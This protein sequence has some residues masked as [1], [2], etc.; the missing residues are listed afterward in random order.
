MSKRLVALLVALPLSLAACGSDSSSTSPESS[1]SAAA[2]EAGAAVDGTLEDVNVTGKAGAEPTVEVTETP[3]EAEET[4]AQV[5]EEGSGDVVVE[6]GN[7][8]KAE[9]VVVNGR[10][11]EAIESSWP[12][13]AATAQPIFDVVEG[14]LLPGL[15]KGLLGQ[16]Q[17]SR[18]AIAAPAA[19][20]FA[21]QGMPQAGIEPG[22]TIVFVLDLLEVTEVEP[23]LEMAEGTEKAPP[24]GLPTLETSDEGVPTGFTADESTDPEPKKLVVAPVI[25]G[26]GPKIKTGQT[27]TVHY[28]GQ[29]YPDGEIFDQSW[30]AGQPFEFQ[31]GTGGVIQGWDQGLEG[32]T[33]GS[34]VILAIP[35]D[36]AYG[37]AGSQSSIPPNATL[38]FSV[39]ILAAG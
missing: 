39:D 20:A 16:Q 11:G 34:R 29:L 18:V 4:T 17:G 25:V 30:T 3:Y 28:L 35:P 36:L 5:I 33:V 32:Q 26:D 27:V 19:D 15:Y 21:E 13:D 38:L 10:T 14:E 8:V 22:D 31:L 23:P 12:D 24:A 9:F 1:A 7:R 2:D 6:E 37:E